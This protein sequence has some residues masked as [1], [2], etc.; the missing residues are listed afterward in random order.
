MTVFP[1]TPPSLIPST[2]KYTMTNSV[3]V[4]DLAHVPIILF[5]TTE[6]DDPS[7]ARG[8][9]PACRQVMTDC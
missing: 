5:G 6:G 9:L 3:V 7:S 8:G 2:T 4:P 1:L